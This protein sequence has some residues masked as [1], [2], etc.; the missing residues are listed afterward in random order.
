VK[1]RTMNHPTKGGRNRPI[2]YYR[3]LPE[4]TRSRDPYAYMKPEL[5]LNGIS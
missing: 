5:S 3:A 4:M 2:N 1:T